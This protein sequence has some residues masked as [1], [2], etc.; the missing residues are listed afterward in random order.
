MCRAECRTSISLLPDNQNHIFHIPVLWKS[1]WITGL[2]IKNIEFKLYFVGFRRKKQN[3]EN[4]WFFRWN[5]DSS[6]HFFALESALFKVRTGNLAIISSE[7]YIK[8]KALL[9]IKLV[10]EFHNEYYFF[11]IQKDFN[12][13][14]CLHNYLCI[15]YLVI[16]WKKLSNIDIPAISPTV[17]KHQCVH[18]KS[19]SIV[20][21]NSSVCTRRRCENMH[22]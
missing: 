4:L 21:L 2:N 12:T 7:N 14:Y 20:Y 6:E 16:F 15:Y 22:V 13:I 19:K 11:L 10:T 18:V 17:K 5:L 1:H 3:L 8:S 9:W